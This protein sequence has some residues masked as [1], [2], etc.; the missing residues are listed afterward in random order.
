MHT[1]ISGDST[2]RHIHTCIHTSQVTQQR[3]MYRVLLSDADKSFSVGGSTSGNLGGGRQT[4]MS[5]G[6]AGDIVNNSGDRVDVEAF[7]ALAKELDRY[8]YI[9][10]YEHV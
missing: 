3:D 4:G 2:A 8:T 9:Y 1:Y 7:R 6:G 5:F 10:M